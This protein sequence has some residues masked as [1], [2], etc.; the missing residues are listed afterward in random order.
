MVSDLSLVRLVIVSLHPAPRSGNDFS[1]TFDQVTVQTLGRS[2]PDG[3]QS[4]EVVLAAEMKLRYWPKITAGNTV[5]VTTAERQRLERV[6]ETTANLIAVF[7][8]TARTISS[9]H[10]CVAFRAETSEARSR[11]VRVA[12]IHEQGQ[13]Q[14][15]QEVYSAIPIEVA[16]TLT[17]RFDGV[18]LLAEAHAQSHALGRY[19]DLVRLFERAFALPAARSWQQL[20]TFLDTR[21]GYTEAELGE[22]SRAR[23]PATHADARAE[24]ALE[25]DV[26]KL[27]PRLEQAARDVLLNKADWRD[28]SPVR[29]EAW[30]PKAW[31]TSAAGGAKV[32]IHTTGTVG[33]RILDQFGVYPS[34]FKRISLPP[35]FWSPVTDE[36]KTP[37][38]SFE[39]FDPNA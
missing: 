20:L 26:W 2:S 19:R 25:P 38:T 27:L 12:G 35:E 9:P 7:E 29:R 6:L 10:P 18:A 34:D 24:F 11:L 3:G 5:V 22:W 14:A 33:A 4:L 31:T 15:V 28:P 17:D 21:Y 30:E 32:R 8:S 13:L 39:V 23:D 1:A 16:S 37:E 36:A